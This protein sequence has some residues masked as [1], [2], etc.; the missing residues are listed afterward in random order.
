MPRS[1]FPRRNK[2]ANNCDLDKNVKYRQ[3]VNFKPFC[4][5]YSLGDD[6]YKFW[7][8]EEKMSKVSNQVV[9]EIKIK[10]NMFTTL[11]KKEKG[12]ILVIDSLEDVHTM[13]KKY[14]KKWNGKYKLIDFNQVAKIYSG[15]EFRNYHKIRK[16]IY[17]NNLYLSDKY[18]WYLTVD[19]NSGC[20]WN[21][22]IIEVEKIGKLKEFVK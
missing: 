11:E 12:K 3:I 21:L 15:I 20:V 1:R 8:E 22:D 19:V 6:W 10:R 5:W 13:N 7:Y 17:E 4:Y 9:C 18:S 16:Y 2:I 14:S